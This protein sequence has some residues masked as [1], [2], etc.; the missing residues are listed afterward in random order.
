MAL[1]CIIFFNMNYLEKSD[2]RIKVSSEILIEAC[3][4]KVADWCFNCQSVTVARYALNE[5]K[6]FHSDVL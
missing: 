4:I 1:L 3:D 6:L 2:F 5:A